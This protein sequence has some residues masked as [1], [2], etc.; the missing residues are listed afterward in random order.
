[1]S[2][3][4]KNERPAPLSAEAL[5]IP[6]RAEDFAFV[7]TQDLPRA[8]GWL[9]QDRAVD[10]IRM[11]ASIE[12]S[13]FNAFVLGTPGSGR[14][15]VIR[16]ILKEA[17]AKKPCPSDWIYVNNFETPDKPIAIEL[18]AGVAMRFRKAME[19]FIDELANDIPALFESDDYQARRSAIEQKF[20][21]VHETKLGGVFENARAREVV[22]LRTPVGFTVAGTQ[23]G[24]VLTPETYEA[25]EEKRRAQVDAAIEET[26]EELAAVLKS[27][28]ALQKQHRHEVEDLNYTMATEG[29]DAAIKVVRDAFAD[30]E[31]AKDYIE[32]VR[33]DLIENVAIF[34]LHE[35]GADAGPFPVATTKHFAKP[36]FRDY[37]VNVIVCHDP[38]AAEGAPVIEED[39]PMLGNLIGRTE[40]ESTMGALNT[41]F[42]KIKPGALHLANGG[43]LVLDAR[44][45]LTEP[46]AWDAL[47]RS[48]KTGRISIYSPAERMSLVSTVSLVPEPIPLKVRVI[49]LGERLH[50]YLLSALD[51]EFPQLFKLEADFNDHLSL[52]QDLKN[53]YAKFVGTV[54]R[55]L[56]I[57][58]LAPDA[59]ARLFKESARLTSDVER[60][61]LNVS[62]LSDMMREADFWAAEQ[63]RKVI[64]GGDLDRVIV[65]RER[66][67]GRIR[68]LS[69]EAIL[70]ETMLID[71]EGEAVGQINA[72]SVLQI[73][74]YSFGRPSRL[75]ARTRMGTGKVVD[76]ERETE[77]GGPIHSKG[78]LILQGYLAATYAGEAPMSLWA[79]LVFEQSYGGVEGDSASAAE[80]LALLSSLAEVPISQSFAITGS[81]NQFGQIQAIGG[82]NEKIEGF[83]DI[84]AARGL[85][86]QQG[87][88]IP[89]A[90]VKHL[91][92]RQRV[93]D[94]VA[95]EQFR[96]I[97]LRSISDAIA[98]TTGRAVGVRDTK[99]EYP[100]DSFN[101]L[102]EAKLRSFA[103]ARRS[104][105]RE[106]RGGDEK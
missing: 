85:T 96:I 84:C 49:L 81:V 94:A 25:L 89:A 2:D 1:M 78:M 4:E 7:S 17:A 38:E 10:A 5:G 62:Q 91:S 56:G 65:E 11:A 71:T 63:G 97:P 54:A 99:G 58:P 64:S 47:K 106:M 44:Q 76:I 60:L 35:E 74:G 105:G 83:F 57:R 93:I 28:P 30:L 80:L 6:V 8:E 87:V 95:A 14:R 51:P 46:F 90:N 45:V 69:Q 27:F 37:T 15:T 67:V 52:D 59:M 53:D 23:E 36:Q 70:R 92:L 16:S 101:G 39:L 50:Y 21:E 42:T 68:D 66:R 79:S 48:L 3:N 72:L 103:E 40:F 34:L 29:V 13:D 12:H 100:T 61:T 20:S 98:T 31:A 26:Q 86:G 9:G 82:V 102:V 32:N 104:F 18:P 88:L 41:D 24:E 19:S 75:T 77:L 73:G 22:I 43:F 55:D 33:H